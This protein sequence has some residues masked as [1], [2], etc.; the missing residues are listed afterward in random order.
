MEVIPKTV[1]E[2]KVVN[3]NTVF[4]PES[5]QKEIDAHPSMKKEK[6]KKAAKIRASKRKYGISVSKKKAKLKGK[7]YRPRKKLVKIPNIDVRRKMLKDE[8][9]QF[10]GYAEAALK[11]MTNYYLKKRLDPTKDWSNDKTHGPKIRRWQRVR[12]KFEL[13]HTLKKNDELKLIKDKR[14]KKQR[15]KDKDG[16]SKYLIATRWVYPPIQGQPMSPKQKKSYRDR[17]VYYMRAGMP[18]DMAKKKAYKKV[19]LDIQFPNEE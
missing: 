7:K 18:E 1:K 15:L 19:L 6:R 12:Q 10:K 17:I 2:N 13:L 11:E 16:K 9:L 5:V 8:Y 4:I 14:L 3:Y